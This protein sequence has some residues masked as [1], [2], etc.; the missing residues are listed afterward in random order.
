[1]ASGSERR[2]GAGINE[3]VADPQLQRGACDVFASLRIYFEDEA[4][5]LLT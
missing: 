4:S 3:D 1:M 2:H 5:W